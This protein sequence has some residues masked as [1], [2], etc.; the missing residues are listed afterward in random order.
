MNYKVVIPSAGIGSRIGPLTKFINKSLVTVGDMPAIAHII[1]KIPAD[2]EIIIPIGY[3]ADLVCQVVRA[4]F[5]KRNIKFVT[6]DNFNGEGSGL[7]YTLNCVKTDLQ[8]PFIF[9]PND[10][11]CEIDFDMLDPNFNGNW[12][13]YYEKKTGDRVPVEQYRT[14]ELNQNYLVDILPKG[15]SDKYVYT[16]ICGIKDFEQFWRHLSHVEAIEV[17][18]SYG[19]KTLK[20]VK[21]VAQENW[22]DIGN[23]DSLNIAKSV[24]KNIDHNILEKENEAIWFYNDKVIKFHVDE[25]FIRDRVGRSELIKGALFPN[26]IYQDKNIYV[27]NKIKGTVLSNVVNNFKVKSLLEKMQGDVWTKIRTEIS[28]DI[29]IGL[30][31]FYRLKTLERVKYYFSRF[32]KFDEAVIVNGLNC[33]PVLKQL[34]NFDWTSIIDAAQIAQFHGDFHSENIIV[35]NNDDFKLIDWRQNF[36]DLG[37][38]IGDVNYDLAKF[39]HGLI[40]AHSQVDAGNFKVKKFTSIE[41]DIEISQSFKNQDALTVLESFCNTYG[42]DFLNI[43]ILTSL[44]FLNIAGLHEHP[45]SEFLFYLGRY[46]LTSAIEIKEGL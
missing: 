2:V 1:E 25:E 17:G 43:R 3:K 19:L 26:I 8:C 4:F 46:L 34:Q 12:L 31:K 44:I 6:V 35:T 22:F 18:E 7:G 39:M 29:K 10:T 23:L 27:Y 37:L 40:V 21:A 11:L 28:T 24:Y 16:G 36:G 38:T 14:V 41:I 5:P 45:Y 33:P 13:M 9:I 42:Y 20:N 30:D 15:V 32:E